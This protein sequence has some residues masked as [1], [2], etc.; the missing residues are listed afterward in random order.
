MEIA[1]TGEPVKLQ[2]VRITAGEK[3]CSC[4][5]AFNQ[6]TVTLQW[7]PSINKIQCGYCRLISPFKLSKFTMSKDLI[8]IIRICMGYSYDSMTMY[9]V[10]HTN[11]KCTCSVLHKPKD[12]QQLNKIIELQSRI[13]RHL[14]HKYPD[15][16]KLSKLLS[17]S[18]TDKQGIICN[19]RL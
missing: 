3:D 15:I 6:V 9:C 5:I 7:F 13:G 18:K 2:C 19:R 17:R 11:F 14:Y 1:C 12:G 8:I 4:S 16:E 10:V